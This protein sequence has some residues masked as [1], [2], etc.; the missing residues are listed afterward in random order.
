[1]PA[2]P[3]RCPPANPPPLQQPDW[4]FNNS[5][6]RIPH[7]NSLSD[8]YC[9]LRKSQTYIK[10][11]QPS[12]LP[13]PKQLQAASSSR[14]QNQN[15]TSPSQASASKKKKKSKKLT[16]EWVLDDDD[17]EAPRA[18][19]EYSLT[20]GAT[21]STIRYSPPSPKGESGLKQISYTSREDSALIP[22]R[23]QQQQ[24]S[25][26]SVALAT[27]ASVHQSPLDST[28]K[29][30][31][32]VG[33][34]KRLSI[35]QGDFGA[36]LVRRATI[37]Q[38]GEDGDGHQ[39]SVVSPPTPSEAFNSRPPTGNH[40]PLAISMNSIGQL[41]TSQT[42]DR[43][44]VTASSAKSTRTGN[45]DLLA[46]MS[47]AASILYHWYDHYDDITSCWAYFGV[48][49]KE[50]AE[51]KSRDD[52][53]RQRAL[54]E[55]I[56]EDRRFREGKAIERDERQQ[57]LAD[58]SRERLASRQ[59]AIESA[60]E[61]A[62]KSW[63]QQ[64]EK[65]ALKQLSPHKPRGSKFDQSQRL[66][67]SPSLM[68]TDAAGAS[69]LSASTDAKS[70]VVPAPPPPP[71][72]KARFETPLALRCG[73]FV[74]PSS[75][76][77]VLQEDT[78]I[79]EAMG[80]PNA[81]YSVELAA[82][83][84]LR[85]ASSSGVSSPKRRPASKGAPRG[86]YEHLMFLVSDQS[87]EYCS[88]KEPPNLSSSRPGS[89]DPSVA[90]ATEGLSGS[91]SR[92]AGGSGMNRDSQPTMGT[93]NT[94]PATTTDIKSRK[95]NDI[96]AK[97][98]R[99]SSTHESGAA[100]GHNSPNTARHAVA[101]TTGG[102][103]TVGRRRN[104]STVVSLANHIINSNTVG[105]NNN[106]AQHQTG[107]D[108]YADWDTQSATSAATTNLSYATTVAATGRSGAG[109]GGGAAG[110]GG[111]GATNMEGAFP[112]I[113]PSNK[114]SSS[115][116]ATGQ[117]TGSS[118][119]SYVYLLPEYHATLA[120]IIEP[121]PTKAKAIL[122]LP[123]WPPS[124][125]MEIVDRLTNPK[126]LA[127]LS[128]VHKS[129]AGA[130]GWSAGAW[131]LNVLPS[132]ETVQLT[133]RIVAVVKPRGQTAATLQAEEQTSTGAG[134]SIGNN[135]QG[136]NNS[137]PSSQGL[138]KLIPSTQFD[139]YEGS[140]TIPMAD[141]TAPKGGNTNVTIATAIVRALE[142]DS[143]FEWATCPTLIS[144]KGHQMRLRPTAA[145]VSK[146]GP[147]SGVLQLWADPCTM[148]ETEI[149]ISYLQD[150][151]SAEREELAKQQAIPS[152][153]RRESNNNTSSPS[154]SPLQ[155]AIP[156][157]PP[158][159]PTSARSVRG[160]RVGGVSSSLP[161]ITSPSSQRQPQGGDAFG[162]STRSRSNTLSTGG[163]GGNTGSPSRSRSYT[164]P[165]AQQQPAAA[166][167]TAASSHPTSPLM[168]RPL[169]PRVKA[170]CKPLGA[171]DPLN[172]TAN[173]SANVIA[174]L[175]APLSPKRGGQEGDRK[176]SG[177]NVSSSS[178]ASVSV[179]GSNKA[180]KPPSSPRK[181]PGKKKLGGK[182]SPAKAQL[183]DTPASVEGIA[184]DG[185][186]NPDDWEESSSPRTRPPTPE[187]EKNKREVKNE[188]IQDGPVL[189]VEPPPRVG[190]QE[191]PTATVPTAQVS[192][193][194]EDAAAQQITDS[195][196][197]EEGL[198]IAVPAP[199]SNESEF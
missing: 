151:P 85:A 158:S 65:E 145:F 123:S 126:Y 13:S 186:L 175:L 141:L 109:I 163:Q 129:A 59:G 113:S 64:K 33:P 134:M 155:T 48:N 23:P 130:G 116:K 78:S 106:P 104:N 17:L 58:K 50:V 110:N 170:T 22:P 79:R 3:Q 46:P 100:V 6:D 83:L 27:S 179:A 147:E 99:S 150:K 92:I 69:M 154:S 164:M 178:N 86:E 30:Q 28:P 139:L 183:G 112:P 174:N 101:N 84:T 190:Q 24:Q 196:A 53:S 43:R 107:D 127:T 199:E 1:M 71:E 194:P 118:T 40:Q 54:L 156:H 49:A 135:Q 132:V 63:R 80:G 12:S 121:N 143:S 169:M 47:E 20:E 11:C 192:T 76:L 136:A 146:L 31:P 25:P 166:T 45:D 189:A 177:S 16:T 193:Q 72:P 119:S 152:K 172:V 21:G 77:R 115:R 70:D 159:T 52:T 62:M 149:V 187:D 168:V 18:F 111:S 144:H 108:K 97:T 140:T 9:P 73:H 42:Q 185:L 98:S 120:N 167:T 51:R 26:S 103:V 66:G 56:E 162:G 157:M 180:P 198:Q 191:E 195:N 55:G 4:V 91:F 105:S 153:R 142:G 197:R 61:A 94:S 182:L 15:A 88:I 137:L 74:L 10:G 35:T 60:L 165:V 44:V 95:A 8:P 89:R 138:K 133:V 68:G 124:S 122:N 117:A 32:L 75:T 39:N 29:A 93:N 176:R 41:Q 148:S 128:D 90:A 81:E 184:D 171:N 57:R 34:T 102:P 131:A 19:G 37:R 173:G 2:N 67:N 82:E 114:G 125:R 38:P 188:T 160:R 14:G 161:P 87:L 5:S 96:G 181:A 36:Q 7:Y